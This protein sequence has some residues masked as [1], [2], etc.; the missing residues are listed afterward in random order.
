MCIAR[1]NQTN[2]PFK[3]SIEIPQNV[4]DTVMRAF[5]LMHNMQSST[6]KDTI[7]NLF[8]YDNFTSIGQPF[9]DDSYQ[10]DST[11]ISIVATGVWGASN[12]DRTK[13][14]IFEVHID[15]NI[16][17]TK[18]WANSNFKSTSYPLMNWFIQQYDFSITKLPYTFFG[19]YYFNLKTTLLKNID[20]LSKAIPS[21]SSFAYVQPLT[22][23]GDG[24]II[25]FEFKNGG[26][27]AT[28]HNGC[29]DCLTGCNYWEDWQ[30][31]IPFDSCSVN[32]LGLGSLQ[33]NSLTGEVGCLRGTITPVNIT[34]FTSNILQ[35]KINL[36]W[37]TLTETN[38][39][40]FEVQHS[41]NGINFETI[42]KV[43]AQKAQGIKTYHYLHNNPILQN[44]YRLKQ[45]DN[46]G[47]FTFSKTLFVKMPSNN[48]LTVYP[49][50]TS[51]FI[52]LNIAINNNNIN[53]L[54]L[55]NIYGKKINTFK[56]KQGNQQLN[57]TGVVTGKYIL[58]LQTKTGEFYQQ[59]I[60]IVN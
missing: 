36:S 47:K 12:R 38:N 18:D 54:L 29:G 32:Y 46:D 4:Y 56:A 40:Y 55:Y 8:Q 34:T 48:P 27:L 24:N 52:N 30:F 41:S 35:N 6:I 2:S 17:W 15:S 13:P 58:Q 45:I 25:N 33:P 20:A 5:A 23:V 31:F 10:Q 7:K 59:Q 26:I 21:Y 37:Q 19:Q 43:E 9:Y 28:Y 49:N 57:I 60:F 50:P 3:D 1:L 14:K 53:Q 44:Q 11:H 42:G 22:Y 51:N 16:L 39:N